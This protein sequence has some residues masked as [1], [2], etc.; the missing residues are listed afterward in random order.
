MITVTDYTDPQGS[1]FAAA[2][3]EITYATLSQNSS[4]E[5]RLNS[6]PLVRSNRSL[7]Y[8]ARYWASQAA[9]DE[10]KLSYSYLDVGANGNH[11]GVLAEGEYEGMTAFEAAEAH[12]T[13][14]I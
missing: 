10:G 12:L 2:V 3:F 9:K 5:Y 8:T 4:E 13:A 11:G 7:H 14:S 6:D 1:V